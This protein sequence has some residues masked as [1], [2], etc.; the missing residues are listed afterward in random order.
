[1]IN[2][3]TFNVTNS[4]NLACKYCFEH[5]KNG[6]I[7]DLE[8]MKKTLDYLY[9]NSDKSSVFYVAFFGGEP[10]LRWNDIKALIKHANEKNYLIEWSFTTNFVYQ[11]T[12]EDMKFIEDNNIYILVSID[13]DKQSHDLNR[14]NS[15]DKVVSNIKTF[16]KHDLMNR[17][18]GRITFTPETVNNLAHNVDHLFNLGF[19]ELG[20]YPV[21][22][23]PWSE[24]NLKSLVNQVSIVSDWLIEKYN[25]IE[26]KQNI[27]IRNINENIILFPELL[28]KPKE[29]EDIKT[30]KCSLQ[31]VHQITINP[32][33]TVHACHQEST[34]NSNLFLLGTID[35][36]L[37]G[38]IPLNNI[39]SK[40][41]LSFLESE[42]ITDKKF[43]FDCKKCLARK[44]CCGCCPSESFRQTGSFNNIPAVCCYLAIAL[45]MNKM[46]ILTALIDAKNIR[47]KVAVKVQCSLKLYET[48]LS[49]IRTNVND[50]G[51]VAEA[52][53]LLEYIKNNSRLLEEDYIR[54]INEG[55]SYLLGNKNNDND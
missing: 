42:R 7:L 30:F 27:D 48:Y 26:N 52:A 43:N 17:L 9:E 33:K 51:V 39:S 21:S 31:S 35:D 32:D 12:E 50:I 10:L 45:A 15:Y 24:D 13:G 49:I 18:E 36:L 19:I 34:T 37:N 55:L 38:D 28:E 46:K 11:F 29:N 5:S 23:V 47:G 20:F 2:S 44:A 8:D 1:M 22:D 14:C 16:K 25:D 53:K 40:L 4:C 54:V 3:V 6:L 41:N